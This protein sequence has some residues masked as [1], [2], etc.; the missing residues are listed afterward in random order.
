MPPLVLASSGLLPG[1][2]PSLLD[3]TLSAAAAAIAGSGAAV[4]LGIW[5]G[6]SAAAMLSALTLLGAAAAYATRDAIRART[7]RPAQGSEQLYTGAVSL[8]DAVSRIIGP[9]LHRA[10]LRSYVMVIVAAAVAVGGAALVGV[11]AF[12]AFSRPL[13]VRSHELLVVTMIAAGAVAATFARSTMAAVLSLGVVGYGVA[14]MFLMF[15]APDLAMTQFSVETLTAVIYV[16]VFRHFRNLGALSPRLV[17]YRDAVIAG[18]VGTFIAGLVLTVSTTHTAPELREYFARFALPLGHGRNIVNVILVDFRGF[19]TLGEITVLAT[20]AIGVRAVLRLAAPERPV[21]QA[22]ALAL[23]TSPIFRTAVRTLMPLL[24]LYAAFLLLRGHNQP[25]GGFVAGL[26]TAAAFALYAI[27]FGVDRAR[28]A[29]PAD[30]LTLIGAGL[31]IALSS[32]VPA[33]LGGQPFLTALWTHTPTAFGT[34]V[35]FDT[36]VFLVVAGVVLMMIFSLAE[37]A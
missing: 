25:G 20:A 24:L 15:G 7:W 19:D 2:A 4:S 29:V 37:E 36:G 10:S 17:R 12:G 5:H 11:R 33:V 26:V 23:P 22:G 27:A 8:L 32:G 34:P 21:A 13:P 28:R 35:V 18:A 1:I 16:L 3:R 9:P 30:P 6:L 31:L 14:T